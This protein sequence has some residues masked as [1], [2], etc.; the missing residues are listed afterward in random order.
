MYKIPKIGE[1]LRGHGKLV[2]VDTV[3]PPPPKPHDEYIF[4]AIDAKCEVRLNGNTFKNLYTLWDFYGLETSITSAIE[5]MI[6]YCKN[7]N[8]TGQSELEVV[9]VK[10]K[11]QHRKILSDEESFYAKG[12]ADFIIAD[13]PN[14]NL[15]EPIEEIVWSSKRDLKDK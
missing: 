6:A 14:L 13:I 4:E 3:Q 5:E 9:V 15:P 7:N 12:F 10:V 1:Y 8:I 2:S 11:S